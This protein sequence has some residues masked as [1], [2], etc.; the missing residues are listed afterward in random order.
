MSVDPLQRPTTCMDSVQRGLVRRAPRPGGRQVPTTWH[1]TLTGELEKNRANGAPAG[2]AGCYQDIVAQ[3][4]AE[5]RW[6]IA[7]EALES[8]MAQTNA[9]LAQAL[10]QGRAAQVE[11]AIWRGGAAKAGPLLAELG[12]KPTDAG[13][14]MEASLALAAIVMGPELM[15]TELVERTPTRAVA[16]TRSCPWSKRARELGI[17][18]SACAAGDQAWNEGL[19]Q[20]LGIRARITISKA[21]SRG[22]SYCEHL[23]ELLD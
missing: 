22:D 3:V 17:G 9:V 11:E 20:A 8:A 15:E 13:E 18:D 4:P 5:T 7:T 1:R 16:R 2:T 14:L 12:I 10:G 6:V 19:A 21:M 23:V